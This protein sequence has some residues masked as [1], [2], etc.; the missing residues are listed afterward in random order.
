MNN[1][2]INVMERIHSV[3][4]RDKKLSQEETES[5]FN[6]RKR[7][8]CFFIEHD[9]ISHIEPEKYGYLK[10][11]Y[12]NGE[13][14]LFQ[15][16]IINY[17]KSNYNE[18]FFI[19]I[20]LDFQKELDDSLLT[21]KELMEA[22][23]FLQRYYCLTSVYPDLKVLIEDNSDYVKIPFYNEEDDELVFAQIMSREEALDIKT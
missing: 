2:N 17:L 6:R 9:L 10:V 15:G 22:T 19:G 3:F 12:K 21:K 16:K 14:K 11:T 4:Y 23:I 5:F 20:N 13:S 18:D 1:S 7:S 8:M